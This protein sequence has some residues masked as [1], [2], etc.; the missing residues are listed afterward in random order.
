MDEKY[1]CNDKKASLKA[2]LEKVEKYLN[3]SVNEYEKAFRNHVTMPEF[4]P[5]S[6]LGEVGEFIAKGSKKSHERKEALKSFKSAI[7]KL[8]EVADDLE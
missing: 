7:N 8:A 6:E 4:L 3:R 5:L 1:P 2:D